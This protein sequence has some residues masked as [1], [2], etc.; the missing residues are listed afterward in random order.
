[1]GGKMQFSRM[2]VNNVERE[3]LTEA[4]RFIYNLTAKDTEDTRTN[5]FN[6]AE[7]LLLDNGWVK[8]ATHDGGSEC[9]PPHRVVVL[10]G[11]V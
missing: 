5:H 3:S 10:E 1:M 8:V 7:I 2:I 6:V 9:F 4:A 11:W